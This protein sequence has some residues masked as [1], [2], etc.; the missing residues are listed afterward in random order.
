MTYYEGAPS[1]TPALPKDV[2]LMIS[3]STFKTLEDFW[4]SVDES[5][6]W[7]KKKGYW[8]YEVREIYGYDM[9]RKEVLR[10]VCLY[11]KEIK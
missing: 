2:P 7:L 6:K 5:K 3:T 1:G 11:Y 10:F 8:I 9:T 4:K